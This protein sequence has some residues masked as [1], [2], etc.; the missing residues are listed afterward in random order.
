M[1]RRRRHIFLALL[2]LLAVPLLAQTVAPAPQTVPPLAPRVEP[3]SASATG[4]ELESRAD[5]L[6]DSKL[7]LDA[8]D[9]YRAALR[10]GPSAALHNKIGITE[11][12]LARMK[13]AK[14]DFQRAIKTDRNYAD[15]YNNLGV[16][17]YLQKKYG[18]AIKQY[19]KAIA[20]REDSAS[21]HSN[22]GTAYFSRKEFTQA[23]TE[24]TRA[25]QLDPEVFE[26]QSRSGVTA[27]MSSPQDRAHFSFVLA[28]MYARAGNLDRCLS[29]L[30]RALEEG[31]KGFDEV[32]KADEFAAVRK[33]P[34][35]AELMASRPPAIPQ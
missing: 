9:Y 5:E 2:L 4:Q 33:D 13:E 35:F 31:Y 1:H 11:L 23:A 22:L 28:K 6:R 24:Y 10:K 12:Q 15:A 19:R 26:R 3:P 18:D 20:L 32:Y 29:H 14:R 34:R 7:Y 21:F 30:R 16:I 17:H 25:L 8:L 27:K